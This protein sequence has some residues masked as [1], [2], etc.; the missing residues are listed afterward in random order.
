SRMTRPPRG[1]RNCAPIGTGRSCCIANRDG[2]PGSPRMCWRRPV[3][4]RCATSPATCPAGAPPDCRSRRPR[5]VRRADFP[6]TC[7]RRAA[8][9]RETWTQARRV[10]FLAG[11][12]VCGTPEGASFVLP[13]PG[14]D[15]VGEVGSAIVAEGET[16]L[17]IARR[18][19][20]GYNEIAAA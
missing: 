12:L 20:L 19:D 15:V 17:D 18:H 13:G 11:L 10:L 8:D 9:G 2:A 14:A 6:V 5:P 3:S 16:L 4:A 7:G 1:W